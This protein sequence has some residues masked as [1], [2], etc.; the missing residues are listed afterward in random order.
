MITAKAA[1]EGSRI[2]RAI[3]V[4]SE[5]SDTYV[6]EW[7]QLP[8]RIGNVPVYYLSWKRI[9]RIVK[10]SRQGSRLAEKHLLNEL[11]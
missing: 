5:C 10:E 2:D 3:V 9:Y 4:I 1:L 11:K 8:V 7:K 6:N